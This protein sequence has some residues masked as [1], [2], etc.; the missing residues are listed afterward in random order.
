MHQKNYLVVWA[1][2]SKNECFMITIYVFL[3]ALGL[4]SYSINRQDLSN[5][6]NKGIRYDHHAEN[7]KRSIIEEKSPYGLQIN[8][9]P[10][11]QIIS[12]DVF[13]KLS[14][15]LRNA[16]RQL[17]E[18]LLRE[19]K[20]VFKAVEDKFGQKLREMFQEN[21]RSAREKLKQQAKH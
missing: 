10:R 6:Y 20:V 15:F 19:T 13:E 18:F 8:K 21:F 12:L 16:E 4:K 7:Y 14:S 5:L 17:T 9:K 11:I 2:M 3:F 1:T